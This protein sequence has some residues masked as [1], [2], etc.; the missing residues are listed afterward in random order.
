MKKLRTT[1]KIYIRTYDVDLYSVNIERLYL[2]N[3]LSKKNENLQSHKKSILLWSGG[4]LDKR[5]IKSWLSEESF[6]YCI[7]A[8]SGAEHALEAGMYV[9]CLMGDLDSIDE[10][11]LEEYEDSIGHIVRFNPEKDDTDT[12]L[13]IEKAISMNPDRVVIVG[14]TG[15]RVDH[16]FT[17]VMSLV[18]YLD[19]GVDIYIQDVNNKIY[20]RDRSFSINKNL[21]Y[22]D[23]ITFVPIS[24]RVVV[25]LKGMKYDLD[26]EEVKRGSRLMQSNEIKLDQAH[27]TIHEGILG[28]F[29][30]RD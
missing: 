3:Y 27:I 26:R 28:V 2:M 25:S 11:I 8:D 4:S 6:D 14:A 15:S 1:D 19:C 18:N 21:Q 9:D 16:V 5:W 22:G 23:Y 30:S 10:H 20:I 24:D 29:E 13:A 17:S 12:G 7:A